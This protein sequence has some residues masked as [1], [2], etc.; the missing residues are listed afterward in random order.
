M[1][2]DYVAN[3]RASRTE[4]LQISL[5]LIS[6]DGLTFLFD[7]IFRVAAE[8]VD[9]S[10]PLT[11]RRSPQPLVKGRYASH[12]QV[13]CESQGVRGLLVVGKAVAKPEGA[14][15]AISTILECAESISLAKG[16][17]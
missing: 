1:R 2:V 8:V 3:N 12:F 16:V 13:L 11:H 7:E 15:E 9:R 6:N 14:S 17:D 4:V 10:T 5:A